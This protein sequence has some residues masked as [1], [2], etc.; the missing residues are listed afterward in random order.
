MHR[1]LEYNPRHKLQIYGNFVPIIVHYWKFFSI[2]NYLESI[3][4]KFFL[5]L[6]AFLFLNSVTRLIFIEMKKKWACS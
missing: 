5:G 6:L 3:C 1:P 4:T 2:E